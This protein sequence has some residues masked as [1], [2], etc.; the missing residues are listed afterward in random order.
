MF[1]SG[2]QTL[3]QELLMHP[4]HYTL[5]LLLAEVQ[6]RFTITS[7]LFPIASAISP[8]VA[9]DMG[10]SGEGVAKP[11]KRKSSISASTQAASKAPR[12]DA[13]IASGLGVELEP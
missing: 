2:Q 5:R 9:P 7:V 3:G 12:I 11:W 6:Y 4:R 1:D 13:G 8:R 10:G